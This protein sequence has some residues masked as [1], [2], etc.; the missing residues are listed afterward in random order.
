MDPAER[1]RLEKAYRGTSYAAGLSLKL[2]VGEP[3]PFLDDMMAF[4]GLEDYAYL[5]AW[6]PGSKP[7]PEAENRA[8]QEA[9]KERLRAKGLKFLEGVARADD[10]SWSEE[11]LLVLGVSRD[12]A[13]ALGRDLGQA[14]VLVGRRGGAP[15]IEWLA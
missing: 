9:L 13:L 5:T 1:E 2:R 15:A 10:G 12:D 6:N 14:A 8:R 11:S 4:R 3:H 7:L